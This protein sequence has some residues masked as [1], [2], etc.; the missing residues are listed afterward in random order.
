MRSLDY[1][2]SFI[3]GFAVVLGT[4][5]LSIPMVAVY[6]HLINPGQPTETY[7]G[8]ATWIAP[9]SS[10]IGGPMIFFWLNRREAG[11]HP[12]TNAVAFAWATIGSYVVI[13]LLSVP[14]FGLALSAVVT[15]PF[16][17]SLAVKAAAALA[18]A[19][20]GSRRSATAPVRAA[21]RG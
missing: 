10:H 6:A 11:R 2:R 3:V 15:M 17:G 8:A 4:L 14:L 18:G 21:A 16:V 20:V 19:L 1:C 9:W 7:H 13:D 12:Q 5:L